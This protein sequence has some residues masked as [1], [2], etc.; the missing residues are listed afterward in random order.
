[1]KLRKLCLA[2]GGLLLG[3]VLAVGSAQAL[4]MLQV[5]APANVGDS[6][7]LADYIQNST[8]PAETNTAI[9]SGNTLYVAGAYTNSS[10]LNIGGQFEGSGA[11]PG[12]TQFEPGDDWSA[13]GF[14]SIFD[15]RGAV[16]MA[17]V[18]NG[19]LNSGSL[20]INGVSAFYTTSVYESGF[21]MPNPPA[22][23]A[24]VP[25]QD[26]LFFDI[27]SFEKNN[28][29]IPNFVDETTGTTT[30]EIKTLTVATT[31]YQW[32]HFDVLA[33]VTMRD[34]ALD[35][36]NTTPWT[37]L[38]SSETNEAGNPGSK[39]VT[40]KQV[41]EPGTLLLLGSG[42]LGVGLMRRKISI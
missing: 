32:I 40:W 36:S 23:H 5:G 18:A 35:K 30:G 38:F 16:L 13:M 17:T 6:G 42:L 41:P 22:N 4:P 8:N 25:G 37:Y 1:M 33:L 12:T 31:G 39:D 29:L 24:P 27:G 21:V 3:S 11:F 28:E 20:T 14:D 2:T 7:V 26:Y 34:D 10:I 19:T 15:N 9:T